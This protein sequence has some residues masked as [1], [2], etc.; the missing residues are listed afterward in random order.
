VAETGGH[1]SAAPTRLEAV[2]E[3]IIEAGWLVAVVLARSVGRTVQG[4]ARR[5]EATTFLVAATAPPILFL[6]LQASRLAAD[7][8]LQS[9]ALDVVGVAR[10]RV[11]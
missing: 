11:R 7:S 3:G 9:A 8:H 2:A 6:M 4:G 5:T 10:R 1:R